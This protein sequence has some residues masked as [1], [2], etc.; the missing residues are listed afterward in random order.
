MDTLNI[1]LPKKLREFVEKRVS[2][3]DY[4]DVSDYLRDVLRRDQKR[5]ASI[6]EIQQALDEGEASG[7]VPFDPDE[8][9]SELLASEKLDAA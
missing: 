3:G 7:F 2:D 8:F 9:L 6:A 5:Q 1:S 4:A